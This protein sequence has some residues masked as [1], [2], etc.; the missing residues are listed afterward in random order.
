MRPRKTHRRSRR[1]LERDVLWT[2]LHH[3]VEPTT[4]KGGARRRCP[5]EEGIISVNGASYKYSCH[6]DGNTY[7]INGG[8]RRPCFVLHMYPDNTQALLLDI[9]R[10][11][12]CSIDPGATTKHAGTA[13]FA[14]AKELGAT[15]IILTDNSTKHLTDTSAFV[16]SDM[17]FLSSG[18]TWYETFLPI[19]PVPHLQAGV[20]RFRN[21]VRQNSWD[22][23]LN[24]LRELHPDI[25]VPVSA[26][27]IDTSAPGSAMLMFRRLKAARTIFFADYRW[28][29]PSCSGIMTLQGSQWIA[30]L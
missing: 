9:M 4:Q 26:D 21:T 13:A 12:T 25:V 1:A 17:E 15:R 11:G 23:V 6:V 14:L 8:N 24:C 7:V 2:L 5:V 16:V 20:E 29:L 19:R 28:E 22:T 3:G 10:S 27:G 30:D 18:R